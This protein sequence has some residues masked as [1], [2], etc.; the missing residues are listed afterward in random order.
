MDNTLWDALSMPAI[1]T[2]IDGAP[3]ATV[4]TE[5][6]TLLSAIV[7]G[8][9]VEEC[10]GRIE[11]F[12]QSQL[13]SGKPVH[14]IWAS[15]LAVEFGQEVTVQFVRGAPTS[16]A[17]KTIE[18]WDPDEPIVEET[19]F[20]LNEED[21]QQLRALP[22][23]R[24]GYRFRLVTPD[25]GVIEM[26]SVA[27]T[28]GISFCVNWN[29]WSPERARVALH[30]YSLGDLEGDTTLNYHAEYHLAEGDEVRFVLLP[31]SI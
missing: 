2:L 6:M 15:D 12:G 8:T 11:I 27:D 20:K 30:S 31:S 23:F 28:H 17:G 14:L 3:V 29:R 26:A 21:I 22:R 4:A 19:D 7:Q 1:R 24:D 10:P 9:V 5:G 16:H 25:G 13:E 18:E